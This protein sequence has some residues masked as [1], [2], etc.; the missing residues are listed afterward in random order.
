MLCLSL[1][2][3]YLD[4][5]HWVPLQEISGI[6]PPQGD[7]ILQSSPHY[8]TISKKQLVITKNVMKRKRPNLS[9]GASILVVKVGLEPTTPAL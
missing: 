7:M 8:T 9:K 2:Q 3:Y 6:K 4:Q 1:R 5:V